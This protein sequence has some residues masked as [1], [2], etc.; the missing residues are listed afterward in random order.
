MRTMLNT[1]FTALSDPTRRA[2]LIKLFEGPAK[3]TQLAEPF[4]VSLP[5]ISKQIR[6]LET[7]GLLVRTKKG[8]EHWCRIN[9]KPM[10]EALN[11]LNQQRKFW[12]GM[13][14]S[15]DEHLKMEKKNG[16]NKKS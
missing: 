11:W 9:P 4:K 16:R 5:A 2:I 7:A 12:D 13:L 14:D 8:R 6:C 1:T 3:V 15:L 10:D